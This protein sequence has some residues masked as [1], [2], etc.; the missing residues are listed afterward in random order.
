MINHSLPAVK[1]RT[2]R[3]ILSFL[4]SSKDQNILE[5][6]TVY[7]LQFTF[8]VHGSFGTFEEKKRIFLFC[9]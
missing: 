1:T 8:S 3:N 4:A 7:L 5:Y 9:F 6:D 2:Y